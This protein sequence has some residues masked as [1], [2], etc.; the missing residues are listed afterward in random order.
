MRANLAVFR[1]NYKDIQATVFVPNPSGGAS[2]TQVV[3]LTDAEINGGELELTAQLLD[4]LV[5]NATASYTD[6]AFTKALN[7]TE[8]ASYP[9]GL[10]SVFT[11]RWKYSMA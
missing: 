2:S 3:N 6:Q 1:S 11:P 10:Q 8:Q 4:E 7:A 9:Q 5:V